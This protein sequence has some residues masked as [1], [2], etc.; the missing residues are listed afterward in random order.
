MAHQIHEDGAG[1]VTT[2][3]GFIEVD[4]DALQL[5]VGVTGVAAG[6][7]N[8]VLIAHHLRAGRGVRGG[9]SLSLS[10]MWQATVV[11]LAHSVSSGY[12]YIVSGY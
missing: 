8:A 4:I 9:A 2:T 5:Q 6:R 3:A 1:N 7:I 11:K 10:R 12:C